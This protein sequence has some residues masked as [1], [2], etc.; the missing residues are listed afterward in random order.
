MRLTVQGLVHASPQ[1]S[2]FAVVF[3]ALE[4]AAAFCQTKNP[5]GKSGNLPSAILASAAFIVRIRSAST[6]TLRSRAGRLSCELL[7]PG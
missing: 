2:M 6:A 1:F 3:V 7:D 4:F 5:F